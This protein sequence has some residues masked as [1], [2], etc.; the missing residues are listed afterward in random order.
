MAE[1][2]LIESRGAVRLL[3]LNRPDKLNAINSALTAELK[4]A[5]TAAN[6][7]DSVAAICTQAAVMQQ[8]ARSLSQMPKKE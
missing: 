2:V 1:A 4:A 3:T 5:L 6:A 7:D 8:M